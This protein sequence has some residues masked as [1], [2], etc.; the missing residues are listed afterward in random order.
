VAKDVIDHLILGERVVAEDRQIGVWQL[1]QELA[2]RQ[3]ARA[4]DADTLD[5]PHN[6][7]DLISKARSRLA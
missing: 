2:R 3:R 5:G 4:I 6:L 7:R 1:I